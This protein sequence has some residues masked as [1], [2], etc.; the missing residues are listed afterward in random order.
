MTK[1]FFTIFLKFNFLKFQ[2]NLGKKCFIGITYIVL[3][4]CDMFKAL[5]TQQ[6][7]TRNASLALSTDTSN[8]NIQD[9][10]L[11]RRLILWQRPNIHVV[12]TSIQKKS[13]WM[14]VYPYS[15]MW[16][17]REWAIWKRNA[18]NEIYSGNS[19]IVCIFLT[20]A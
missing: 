1:Y 18:H 8:H 4:V 20:I 13:E 9:L 14:T 16:T 12:I 2:E 3:Y 15:H 5:T 7:V 10:T 6:T 11:W 19:L 17:Y